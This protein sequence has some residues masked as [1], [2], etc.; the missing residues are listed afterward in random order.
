MLVRRLD[1]ADS[2]EWEIKHNRWSKISGVLSIHSEKHR[3]VSRSIKMTELRA[4]CSIEIRIIYVVMRVPV[5]LGIS[6]FVAAHSINLEK[7]PVH[8]SVSRSTIV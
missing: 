2:S 6:N 8:F 4:N 1:G 7:M 3:G 5:N